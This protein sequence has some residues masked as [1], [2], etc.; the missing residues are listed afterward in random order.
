MRTM[1]ENI[2]GAQKKKSG[3]MTLFFIQILE[4]SKLLPF[5]LSLLEPKAISFTL[6][7]SIAF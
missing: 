2:I 5:K 7:F 6:L 1:G 3:V 4:F